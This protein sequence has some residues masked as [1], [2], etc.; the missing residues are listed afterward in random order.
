MCASTRNMVARSGTG[1][2][3]VRHT[4]ASGLPSGFMLLGLSFGFRVLGLGFGF[5]FWLGGTG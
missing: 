4:S 1:M 5:G 2:Q 3:L